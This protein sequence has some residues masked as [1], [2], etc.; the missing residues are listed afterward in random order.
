M[1]F[2]LHM[3]NLVTN[4]AIQNKIYSERIN[5]WYIALCCHMY[6]IEGH[7]KYCYESKVCM[8]NV[9]CFKTSSAVFTKGLVPL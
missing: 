3:V 9:H 8:C 1:N 4:S 6:Q 2:M 7:N 5:S